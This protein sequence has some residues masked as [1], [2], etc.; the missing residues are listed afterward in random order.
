MREHVGERYTPA[1]TLE[2]GCSKLPKG[3]PGDRGGDRRQVA[4]SYQRL[5]DS[6][7]SRK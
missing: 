3:R 4:V 2:W 5:R 6:Q 7:S 1:R